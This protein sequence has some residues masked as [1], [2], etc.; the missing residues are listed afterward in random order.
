ME[1]RGE[2]PSSTV[3]CAGRRW[4]D[5]GDCR[6]FVAKPRQRAAQFLQRSALITDTLSQFF[7]VTTQGS[8]KISVVRPAIPLFQ[9]G[10]RRV[11]MLRLSGARIY[12]G[13][14]IIEIDIDTVQSI[15]QV[16]SNALDNTI[17]RLV[18]VATVHLPNGWAT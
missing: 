10:G 13:L 7:R 6:Q 11:D 14:Q 12:A 8:D 4:S 3:R 2:L 17:S 16:H 18:S 9:A 5:C 15:S 1:R